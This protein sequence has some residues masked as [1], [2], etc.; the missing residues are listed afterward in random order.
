MSS[1]VQAIMTGFKNF[2]S[3]VAIPFE[4][5]TLTS[6]SASKK[7]LIFEQ[8]SKPLHTGMFKSIMMTE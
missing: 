3:M 2:K 1:D 8:A 6:L 7:S 4:P 5:T